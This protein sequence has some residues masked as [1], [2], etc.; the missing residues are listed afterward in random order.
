[1][2]RVLF[3]LLTLS[4]IVGAFGYININNFTANAAII[5]PPSDGD[6]MDEDGVMD[7]V[8]LCADTAMDPVPNEKHYS[9][10]GG[11]VFMTTDPK[12][13]ELVESSYTITDT[14]GCSCAQI[15]E[16]K[17]GE[18]NGEQKYACTKGTMDN[19]IKNISQE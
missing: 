13:K 14:Q 4:V 8:D 7:D 18:N 1:M 11:E 10:M 2:R 15:L 5:I 3:S 16:E 6:D 19:Y 9:W 17:S 12:T